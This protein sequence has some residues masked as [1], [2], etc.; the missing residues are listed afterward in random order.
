MNRA[1][2]TLLV[3]V[4]VTLLIIMSV[5]SNERLMPVYKQIGVQDSSV[6]HVPAF[7]ILSLLFTLLFAALGIMYPWAWAVWFSIIVAIAIELIQSMVPTRT[8]S[9]SD[10]MLGLIGMFIYVVTH[11]TI[12]RVWTAQEA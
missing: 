2:L 4:Y 8:A 12:R 5:V 6:L 3:L 9:F 11:L 1:I 10:F 7:F